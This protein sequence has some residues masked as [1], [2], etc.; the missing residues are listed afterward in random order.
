MI[1]VSAQ[2]IADILNDNF[3]APMD[4]G[5]SLMMFGIDCEVGKVFPL[6]VGVAGLGHRL[7]DALNGTATQ[8]GY[9]RY[10]DFSK[11]WVFG[12]NERPEDPYDWGTVYYDRDINVALNQP[13]NDMPC[14]WTTVAYNTTPFESAWPEKI[15]RDCI[16]K[17]GQNDDRGLAIRHSPHIAGPL[18]LDDQWGQAFGMATAYELGDMDTYNPAAPT[19]MPPGEPRHEDGEFAYHFN[20]GEAWPRGIINHILGFSSCGG[21]GSTARMYNEP[22]LKKFEQP[23][24]SGV[25]YPNLTVR[26]AWYDEGSRRLAVTVGA[27]QDASPLGSPTTLTVSNLNGTPR[28]LLDGVETNSFNDKGNGT[29]VIDATIGEHTVVV[30]H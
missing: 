26:Q 20:L 13:Q 24:L 4:E 11:T 2:E 1:S 12:G 21:P 22:N 10:L 28:V 16:A 18:T 9:Q 29:I 8:A 14:F 7:W 3:L 5:G 25:D 27:G 15:L 30:S 17:F 19:W 23:T 6:C